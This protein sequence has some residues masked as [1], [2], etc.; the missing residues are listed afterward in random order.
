M[1]RAELREISPNDYFGWEAFASS[2]RPEPWDDFGWFVLSIGVEGQEG[3]YLFQVLVATPAAV[4]RARKDDGHR[5]VLVVD[6]FAP[7]DLAAA[8]KEHVSSITAPTW[9]GIVEQLQRTM[10]WEYEKRWS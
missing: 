10:Y 3:S 2:D 9:D 4:T 1:L 6:S 7:D 5:R 8:L